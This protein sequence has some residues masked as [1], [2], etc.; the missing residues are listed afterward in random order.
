M[1]GELTLLSDVEPTLER[2]TAVA[3]TVHPDGSYVGYRGGDIKQF[4]DA[5][6]T[7][8]LCL[9]RTRPVLVAREAAQAL[10]DPPTAFALW[11][12]LTLPYG[13]DGRGRA[14]AQAIA[15]AVGGVLAAR[16]EEVDHVELG[17]QAG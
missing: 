10:A 15:D 3:A 13:D 5:T 12:D 4:V 9:F 16:S 1:P 14:L 2:V 11:T 8:L 7:P 17:H 6:G